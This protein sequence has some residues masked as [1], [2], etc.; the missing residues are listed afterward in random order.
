MT[1][2][3][4]KTALFCAIL[5]LS[6]IPASAALADTLAAQSAATAIAGV[7]TTNNSAFQNVVS[8]PAVTLNTAGNVLVVA[9]FSMNSTTVQIPKFRLSDGTTVTNASFGRYTQGSNDHGLAQ[10][11]YLFNYG[12]S[13]TPAFS[14]QHKVEAGKSATLTTT[15][16]IVAIPLVT[17]TNNYT[18]TSNSATQNTEQTTTSTTFTGVTGTTISSLALGATGDFYVAA[19]L[20]SSSAAGNTTGVWRL[21][22]KPA[23]GST[24][25]PVGFEISRTMSGTS[26]LGAVCL[27]GVVKGLSAGNYDF[28]VAHKSSDGTQIGTNYV[29]IV[30][31]A[32]ANSNVSFDTFEEFDT[33]VT[34]TGSSETA[35]ITKNTLT[36]ANN[37][38]LFLHAVY[39]GLTT[40]NLSNP[41]AEYDLYVDNAAFDGV[42]Q[43]RSYAKGSYGS[44]ASAG[45]ASSLTASTTYNASLRH[46]SDGTVSLATSGYLLGI[47]LNSLNTFSQYPCTTESPQSPGETPGPDNALFFDSANSNYVNVSDDNSLDLSNTWSMEC[48]IRP[49]S[50]T[51]IQ[52]LISKGNGASLF[53][54][55]NQVEVYY[56][57]TS[58]YTSTSTLTACG[59]YHVAVTFDN[60]GSDPGTLTLYI[61][62]VSDGT[63]SVNAP[64]TNATALYIGR[65]DQGVTTYYFTGTLDEVKIWNG[66]ALTQTQVRD[67]MCSKI[68]SSHASWSNLAGYWKFDEDSGA[69]CNDSSSN[70]NTGT[71][72]NMTDTYNRVCSFAPIGDESAHDYAGT[73]TAADY[74]ATLTYTPEGDSMTVTGDG[75]TWNATTSGIHL[76]RVDEPTSTWA[77]PLA[78][79]DGYS[80]DP[81]RYWGVFVTGGTS[82]TYT[83][84]YTYTGHTGIDD[85]STLKLAYRYANCDVIW[86]ALGA[87]LNTTTDT[88][89][90]TGLAG[91]EFILGGAQS[92]PDPLVIDLISFTAVR[93]DGGNSI[94]VEW[95]TAT[96]VLNAGFYLYRSER[97]EGLY[98]KLTDTLIPGEGSDTQGACYL[99]EDVDVDATTRYWYKLEDIDTYGIISTVHGPVLTDGGDGGD[100]CFISTLR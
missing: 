83:V 2:F 96:E 87:T 14:L 53:L 47:D 84:A 62:G 70:T 7:S 26:K 9:A 24:W 61:N 31:V 50:V 78:W 91:T 100:S 49:G 20:N 39:E 63:A 10:L 80:L 69:S 43:K 75:G 60:G 38:N 97:K 93:S 41:P 98:V 1:L 5:L 45:L 86:K 44:G 48:W 23:A 52:G 67:G 22:Y 99:Y 72:A 42:N 16:T 54:N 27:N 32:L 17:A 73:A 29:N 30:A 65:G 81:L 59:F 35:A 88:L 3:F 74:S 64:P 89:T 11:V 79:G 85:E 94:L 95:E 76:Y 46:K 56:N 25:T 28:R 90:K 6:I 58:Q 34:T 82:P 71:T 92:G 4:R 55:G 36:P 68:T 18:M 15:G 8:T 12:A 57:G 51:G 33:G 21:E 66:V 37:T 77:P 19:S 13:G 40:A